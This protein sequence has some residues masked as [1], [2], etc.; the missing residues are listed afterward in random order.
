MKNLISNDE[1]VKEAEANMLKAKKNLND[2]RVDSLNEHEKYMAV[3]KEKF[4]EN[5]REIAC[6][7]EKIKAEGV[8]TRTE[9]EIQ[10]EELVLKNEKLKIKMQE[11]S[12][13]AK[14]NWILFKNSFNEAMDD[15]GKSI[16]EFA[17]KNL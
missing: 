5:E 13:S 12:E 11:Y 17:D 10:L 9:N 6:L 14:E 3:L 4:S 16:S 1:I 15:L 2:A 8:M 7:K